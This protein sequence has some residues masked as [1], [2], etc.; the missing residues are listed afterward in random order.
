[1][2]ESGLVTGICSVG[3]DACLAG[4]IPT[5]GVAFLTS[6][7]EAGAGIVISASHNPYYDN[8]IKIFNGSGYKLS[9]QV[10]AEIEELILG[11]DAAKRR[12]PG[13][14]SGRVITDNEMVESYITFLNSSLSSNLSFKGLKIV[15]DCANGATCHLAPELFSERGAQ[16]EALGIQPDGKNINDACGS[17]HPEGL[18]Q[19]NQSED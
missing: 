19:M 18:I 1:M 17:E 2:V 12:P 10:E 14:K 13:L 3:A 11:G 7:G 4:V 8:G 15:L 9:D 6:S 16:I 5:P